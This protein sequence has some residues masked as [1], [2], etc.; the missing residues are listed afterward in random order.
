MNTETEI[1]LVP[2]IDALQEGY[3]LLGDYVLRTTGNTLPPAVITVA[4]DDSKKG[5][6]K[7]GHITVGQAWKAGETSFHEIMLTGEGLARGAR[8]TFGTLAHEASHAYNIAQG[9]K[10]TDSNGR[11]NKHFQKTAEGLFFLTIEND[12]ARGWSKTTVSDACASEW[13]HIIEMIDEAL[14]LVREA[15]PVASKT[16]GRNKNL[17]KAVC[18]CGDSIR[19]SRKVIDKGVTCDECETRFT[20]EE[21]EG[22]S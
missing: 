10:D 19:A 12:G 6:R 16:K 1:S 22:E 13:S 14:I 5:V 21:E 4:G 2:L 17:L 3:R 7:Y 11:H 18:E 15:L 20:T 9:V 8:A